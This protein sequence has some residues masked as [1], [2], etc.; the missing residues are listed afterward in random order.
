MPIKFVSSDKEFSD[1]IRIYGYE[2]LNTSYEYY[3][4]T[5]K[6]YYIYP[7]NALC[8]LEYTISRYLFPNIEPYIKQLV[9][10][11]GNTT[12]NGHKY[13]PIGSSL[14][15]D[16][17]AVRSLV[18]APVMLQSPDVSTTYNAYYAT[19]AILY[20]LVYVVGI[21]INNVDVLIPA[22]CTGA[23]MTNEMSVYQIIYGI[24]K[25]SEYI[26]TFIN[27]Y[28]RVVICEPNLYQQKNLFYNA[29]WF[30]APMA[31]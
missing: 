27:S 19:M 1:K 23:K 10:Y 4:P 24:V 21:D 22:L 26:P 12:L 25:F 7:V 31:L 9:N 6:T 11:F 3:V 2:V 29:E 14:V 17:D 15:I 13:L 16:Y 28:Y 30:S 20:N 18:I 5:R 8:D